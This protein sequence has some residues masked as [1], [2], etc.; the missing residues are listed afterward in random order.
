LED[1]GKENLKNNGLNNKACM[2]AFT[3]EIGDNGLGLYKIEFPQ[4]MAGAI[5]HE[6]V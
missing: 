5:F 4:A 3:L 2:Y 6:A 1:E